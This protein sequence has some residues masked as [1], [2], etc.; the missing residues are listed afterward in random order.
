MAIANVDTMMKAV[1]ATNRFC[2]IGSSTWSSLDLLEKNKEFKLTRQGKI[3]RGKLT[4]TDKEKPA[5][6]NIIIIIIITTTT[7]IS[8]RTSK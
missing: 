4:I 8:K 6:N 3:I 2:G 5:S 7:V 1:M